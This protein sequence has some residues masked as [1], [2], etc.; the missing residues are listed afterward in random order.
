MNKD[1]TCDRLYLTSTF[2]HL[3]TKCCNTRSTLPCIQLMPVLT[4]R[5]GLCSGSHSI[6]FQTINS[7]ML[8]NSASGEMQTRLYTGSNIMATTTSTSPMQRQPTVEAAAS[9]LAKEQTLTPPPILKLSLFPGVMKQLSMLMPPSSST[10]LD[11][12]KTR[13]VKWMEVSALATI[14]DRTAKRELRQF[15]TV[16]IFRVFQKAQDIECLNFTGCNRMQHTGATAAVSNAAH[17][18]K[19]HEVE[20]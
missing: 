1:A 4:S 9:I 20:K 7:L 19:N 11:T 13:A 14:D 17:V 5:C 6:I 10:P 3:G 8:Q 16:L 15:T 2:I 12:P 18:S